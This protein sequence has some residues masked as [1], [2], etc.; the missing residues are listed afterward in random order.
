MALSSAE[1]AE[2]AILKQARKAVDL[3]LKKKIPGF[4]QADAIHKDIAGAKDAVDYGRGALEGGKYAV[5]PERFAVEYAK[6]DPA[7]VNDGLRAD[8]RTAVG[9]QA[10][11]LPALRKKVGGEA[12]WNRDKLAT[13]FGP[14][15]VDRLTKAIDREEKFARQGSYIEG[16][17]QTAPRLEA[18]RAIR[19]ADAPKVSGQE[20]A[21]GLGLK[22][23]AKMAN[24]LMSKAKV[25]ASQ[26]T[27][28]ALAKALATKG[29]EAVKLLD[30]IITANPQSTVSK[31][32][33]RALLAGHAA[34][35]VHDVGR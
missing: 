21:I 12:D 15:A 7:F 11:D 5:S 4:A 24:A 34:D 35:T 13:A 18:E 28:E 32:I 19:G 1:K 14:Q 33:I 17:S 26:P 10:N 6:R 16:G 25:R 31:A 29:P 9:T 23:I 22:G 30:R 8:V 2:Q 20:T 27:R 3:V